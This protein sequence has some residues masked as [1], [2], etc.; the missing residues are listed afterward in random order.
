MKKIAIVLVTV[1]LVTFISF[2]AKSQDKENSEPVWGSNE[3]VTQTILQNTRSLR[4]KL[5]DDPYR[6]AYHFCV[7]EDDGSPGDPNG[8]FFKDGIY[9]LMYLY[10]RAGSGFSWGHISSKDL[11]H[12]RQHSDGIG[13]GPNDEGVFSGGGFVDDDGSVYLSYWMLWGAKG[14]GIAKSTDAINYKKYDIN[15][16]IKSTEFGITDTTDINGEKLI[17]GSADPSNIWKKD[18]KYYM[19][20]GNLLA[21]RKYGSRGK[22][23]P[24]NRFFDESELPKD[25]VKYQGDWLDLFVSEDLKKWDYVHRFYESKREWTRKTEDNMCPS[26][27]PLPTNPEGGKISDK[28]LLLFISHNK[29]CQYYIGDYKKDMFSPEIHGRMTWVDNSYFAPEALVD[30]KGRQIMWSWIF[31]DRP[32]EVK[33]ASGWTGTYGLPRS[34][35]LRKDGTLGITPIKEIE[36]LRMHEKT[37]NKIRI[38]AG[39]D[40]KMD[41]FSHELMELEIT[42]RPNNAE[43]FGIKLCQSANGQEE[44]IIYYDN[45][46]KKLKFDTQKSS[47]GYGRKV[48]EAAPLKVKPNESVVMRIFVDRSIVEVFANDRQAIARS[49]YP[50]LGGTGIS[51]FSEGGNVEI[52]SFKTWEIFPSNP[53]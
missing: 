44:T 24:S 37:K 13:V 38:S 43:R 34:L 16:I 4:E 11:I 9:H 27:F 47:L 18:G 35:W 22:G 45:S 7:P 33:T 48:I 53:Y 31:D 28:H 46:D 42:F 49:V 41:E 26:F 3:N 2:N 6:P 14:I 36:Q 25:S 32:G 12:W 20:T 40:V 52:E 30:D 39:K 23:L 19:L 21:L 51:L 29:G 8:A 15:P 10:K 1:F 5:L 50:T 17:Y